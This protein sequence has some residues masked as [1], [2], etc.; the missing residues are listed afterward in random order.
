MRTGHVGA[1]A[2]GDAVQQVLPQRPLLR[3]V[4]SDQQRAAG[5]ADADALALHHVDAVRQDAEQ[6]VGDAV[7]QQVDL[8]HVAVGGGWRGLGHVR[9]CA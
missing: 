2:D 7:V 8:V 1:E 3:V 9:V 4:G 5:V 6:E